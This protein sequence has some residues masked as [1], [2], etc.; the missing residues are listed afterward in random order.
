MGFLFRRLAL[1]IFPAFILPVV[2]FGCQSDIGAFEAGEDEFENYYS[3]F[4]SGSEFSVS[5]QNILGNYLLREALDARAPELLIKDMEGTLLG[6]MPLEDIFGAET[7]YDMFL[8]LE[9]LAPKNNQETAQAKQEEQKKQ[10]ELSLQ[11]QTLSADDLS[12][13]KNTE[14]EGFNIFDQQI[15]DQTCFVDFDDVKEKAKKLMG[16]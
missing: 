9:K 5:A 14:N 13:E 1:K 6:Q 4:A 8:D 12:E 7:K 3:A 10:E 16:N 2:F 11:Q 15:K